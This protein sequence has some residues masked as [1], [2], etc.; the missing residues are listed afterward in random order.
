MTRVPLVWAI[1]G[2]GF[3]GTSTVTAQ[4]NGVRVELF[5]IAQF[6]L[7]REDDFVRHPSGP[8]RI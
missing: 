5:A 1:I 6:P 4:D 3:I 8:F 2:A 7:L